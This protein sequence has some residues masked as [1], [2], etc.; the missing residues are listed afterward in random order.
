MTSG[1]GLESCDSAHKYIGVCS[2]EGNGYQSKECAAP[3]EGFICL[4]ELRSLKNILF[5]DGDHESAYPLI[6]KDS[7]HNH[8]ILTIAFSDDT[9]WISPH[10]AAEARPF[11]CL[12]FFG[13][14]DAAKGVSYQPSACY[15][16]KL[17]NDVC[18]DEWERFMDS[19]L[20][21]DCDK[22]FF[23]EA[24]PCSNSGDYGSANVGM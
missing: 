9:N 4:E 16:R 24:V 22:E 19:G 7:R 17:K 14:C 6:N 12:H 2:N 1:S 21:P 20:L 13:L 11:L 23:N 10:C 5:G 8:A 18:A 3:G 15:C